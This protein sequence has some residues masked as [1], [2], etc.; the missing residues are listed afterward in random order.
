M[1]VPITFAHI[2]KRKNVKNSDNNHPH[3]KVLVDCGASKSIICKNSI[4]N[5]KCV[6]NTT[7]EWVTPSG[8]V[9]SNLMCKL[10]FSLPEFSNSRLITHNFHVMD[11]VLPGYHMIIGRDLMQLL[12]LDNKYSSDTLEWVGNREIPLKPP[13]AEKKHIFFLMIQL[14]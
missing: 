8:K 12:K 10:V 11:E 7:T 5:N 13:E 3:I 14:I 4:L 9:T 2:F 1:N 6:K